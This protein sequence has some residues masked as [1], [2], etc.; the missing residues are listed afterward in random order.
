M[1]GK[2]IFVSQENQG[3]FENINEN[4]FDLPN[5]ILDERIQLL[6]EGIAPITRDE[7]RYLIVN[8]YP[9]SKVNLS[10]IT[11][12]SYIFAGVSDVLD[13]I[14]CW[15]F[16]NI[17]IANNL[18]QY[19]HLFNQNIGCWNTKN[20]R[21]A[22][23]MFLYCK[24]FNQPLN[25]W[26]TSSLIFCQ[27]MFMSCFAFN[28]PLDKWDV[29]KVENFTNMFALCLAFNQPLNNWDVRSGRYFLEMF[30]FCMVLNQSFEDWDLSSAVEVVSMFNGCEALSQDF[31]RWNAL[32][33]LDINCIFQKTK[34]CDLG[35]VECVINAMTSC[36]SSFGL[37]ESLK[38]NS[39]IYPYLVHSNG[40]DS[41]DIKKKRI[42]DTELFFISFKD[43]G[44]FN[45]KLFK[46]ESL[47]LFEID[48]D[49]PDVFLTTNAALIQNEN[50]IVFPINE[51]QLQLIN[52]LF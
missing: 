43:A 12:V 33:S 48:G 22:S 4:Q 20:L 50:N 49:C 11:D 24:Q 42:I 10:E 6:I 28:Q 1:K 8:D 25:D 27:F 37:S 18:F 9:F 36:V 44:H 19:C 51:D 3:N 5:S 34:R 13:D 17:E 38:E 46:S 40:V 39:T 29:S 16:S 32:F 15:D 47:N 26:D 7:L 2:Y 41:I 31:T 30:L 21:N 14:T 23:K 52:E 45:N 35:V